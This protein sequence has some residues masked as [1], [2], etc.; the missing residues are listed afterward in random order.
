MKISRTRSHL[1]AGFAL[2]LAFTTALT[3][4]EA[5]GDSGNESPSNS[6]QETTPVPSAP[7]S[8]PSSSKPKPATPT[9]SAADS[10]IFPTDT[11]PTSP[12]TMNWT[13]VFDE[14]SSGVVFVQA[15]ACGIDSS[16]SAA[17]ILI[18]DDLVLTAAHVV[19]EP[20]GLAGI[21]LRVGNQIAE[22]TIVG[23]N[24]NAD[25]ALLRSSSPLVG[26]H[27]TFASGTVEIGS[28][29]AGLGFPYSKTDDRSDD[30][31]SKPKIAEGTVSDLDQKISY[32][33][34]NYIKNVMQ[35]S[36]LSNGGN[37]GGPVV[38]SSGELVGVHIASDRYEQ[39]AGIKP[40]AY[41]VE[42]PRVFEAVSEWFT[43]EAELPPQ[44]C[45]D[46][47]A[48]W[49]VQ[50]DIASDHDQATNIGQSFKEHA[51]AINRGDFASAFTIFTEKMI[52]S[53]TKN[54]DAWSTGLNSSIWESLVVKDVETANGNSLRATIA[55]VTRQDAEDG[56][57]ELIEPTCAK[58]EL[59]YGMRWDNASAR[60]L[61][62]SQKSTDRN[63]GDCEEYD[64]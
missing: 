13:E 29:L 47:G 16:G 59:S 54:V 19:E 21:D 48:D 45:E 51:E 39:E 9:E 14:V 30:S 61:V 41:A 25:L 11:P 6:F 20:D 8:T 18:G 42:A 62:N 27:F 22:G 44:N 49:A 38:N 50:L 52:A 26:H 60:W 40:P 28:S 36:V 15:R 32:D 43:R 57:E 23:F 1:T 17:G 35:T 37:S 34:E 31:K 46:I 55:F 2:G 33:G 24:K 58:W 5:F 53:E 56:P 64:Y 10:T 63:V 4:C 7:T 3:G 12:V